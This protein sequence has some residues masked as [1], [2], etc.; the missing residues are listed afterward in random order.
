M[1]RNF[2]KM[3]VTFTPPKTVDIR[4]CFSSGF[5]IDDKPWLN[6]EGWRNKL[7]TSLL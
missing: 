7:N 3:G 1:F 4:S 6:D 5:W 2:G